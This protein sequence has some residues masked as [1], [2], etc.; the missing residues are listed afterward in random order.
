[1]N[2]IL[3]CLA[4]RGFVLSLGAHLSALLGVD[5][6]ARVPGVWLLH[7]GIF[8]VFIPMVL[9]LRSVTSARALLRGIPVW[10]TLLLV[11]LF[12][13]AFVNFVVVFGGSDWGA[14]AMRGD[15]FVLERKGVLI[16]QITE[17]EYRSLC[18][19]RIRG[20]SGHWLVFYFVPFTHFLL[21]RE[22]QSC[23]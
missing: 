16:R 17:S 20:F 12:L 5:V 2:T 14:P 21:R 9:Q 1:M 8:L 13:Y 4:L 6:Q 18:A 23:V 11:L 7:V 19:A 10:A 3:G 22:E 15:A